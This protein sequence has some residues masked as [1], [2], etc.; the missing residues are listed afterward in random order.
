MHQAA[1]T[2]SRHLMLVTGV[3]GAGKTLVGLRTVHSKYL[4]D[5]AVPRSDGKP[6]TTRRSFSAATDRSSEVLQY[7]LSGSGGGGRDVCVR[8][9][10]EYV[11]RYSSRR[12]SVP[13]EHV[14]V[15]DEAQR[16]FD[17]D[18]M[19]SK[20]GARAATFQP[21]QFVEFADRVPEW[22]VV[23]GLIGSGQEIHVGEEGGVGQWGRLAVE[24]SSR[25][26]EWTVHAP[27]GLAKFFSGGAIPFETRSSLS[28][29]RRAE[30]PHRI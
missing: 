30:L 25:S 3:P 4:D 6:T 28:L 26:A 17:A 15:F 10:K 29:R 8:G 1:L 23:V 27:P 2:K 16:A 14:L 13:P 20:H 9:V 24:S 19:A 21:E 22:C 11:K 18:M 12:D 5:L 7:E